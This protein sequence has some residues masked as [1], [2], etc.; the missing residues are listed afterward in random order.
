MPGSLFDALFGCSHR[1]TTFPMTPVDKTGATKGGMYVVCL[2]CGKQFTYDWDHMRI[3]KP[4]DISAGPAIMDREG[5]R[6]PFRAKS[7]LRLALWASAVPAAWVI[8]KAII[9]RRRA[10][11]RSSDDLKLRQVRKAE[12]H[13]ERE[14]VPKTRERP[15]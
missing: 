1:R 7:K 8:G 4:V 15:R 6:M 5:P 11:D 12:T 13:G 3:G 9:S 10:G 2:E 14:M